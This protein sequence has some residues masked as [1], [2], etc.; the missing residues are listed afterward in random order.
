VE[1]KGGLEFKVVSLV[2][3]GDVKLYKCV[4]GLY[5]E[6]VTAYIN[7]ER[8]I[9]LGSVIHLAPVVEKTQIYEDERNIR[10]Y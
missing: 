8:D 2:N 4:G 10:L 3:Y 5:G 7:Q 9:A 1:D 6:K